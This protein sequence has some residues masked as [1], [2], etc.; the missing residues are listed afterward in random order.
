MLHKKMDKVFIVMKICSICGISKN[1]EDFNNQKLGKF[2][3]RS[4]CR[5]CQSEQKKKYSENNR[6]RLSE[7]QRNYRELNP[8]YNSS[9]QKKRRSSDLNYRLMGNMRARICNI[10]NNKTTNTFECIGLDIEEFKNYIQS[11]FVEGM[12]WENYGEWQIDHVYPI[13]SGKNEFEI[14]QLNHYT[15]L[16]P[17]WKHENLVKSN[18]IIIENQKWQQ[19]HTEL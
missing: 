15:N 10:L 4:Y 5:I 19:E 13:S 11:K 12:S 3:K 9:Y 16:R 1:L 18:K 2:G 7:Y 8:D 17:L 6:E 14:C